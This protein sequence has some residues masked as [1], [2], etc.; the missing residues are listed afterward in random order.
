[1][2]DDGCKSNIS[3]KEPEMCRTEI[4]VFWK[5]KRIYV[6]TC[7][8]EQKSETRVT[9]SGRVT[10]ANKFY[11]IFLS[12]AFVEQLQ[13][14]QQNHTQIFTNLYF[15]NSATNSTKKKLQ[16]RYFITQTVKSHLVVLVKGKGANVK[17]LLLPTL[18]NNR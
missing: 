8:E 10:K 11:L 7:D 15:Q 3:I 18:E 1:M 5:F 12:M 4:I 9:Y 13:S 2:N 16:L 17:F 14:I 6:H